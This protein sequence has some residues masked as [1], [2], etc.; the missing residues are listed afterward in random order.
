MIIF[1]EDI[2]IL[3]FVIAGMYVLFAVIALFYKGEDYQDDK[4]EF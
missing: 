2:E 1:I 4:N 3:M